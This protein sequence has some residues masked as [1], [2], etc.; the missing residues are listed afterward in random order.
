MED[1][2]R[3]DF[4]N[5]LINFLIGIWATIVAFLGGYAGIRY[6]WP[7]AK[8]AGP[9]GGNKVSFPISE[10]PEGGIKKILINGKPV[11]VIRSG[12]KLYALSLICT[13]LGCIVS[14]HPEVKRLICP[15]HGGTYDLTGAVLAGPPPRPLRSYEV[16]L[17]GNMVV[18]G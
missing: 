3:R 10:L 1:T 5:R 4:L 11:G 2:S 13:H 8:T 7:T 15:C 12:G 14:W 17:V 18:V 9:T 16:K 6:V